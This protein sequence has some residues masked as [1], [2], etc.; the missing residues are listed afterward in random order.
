MHDIRTC[1]GQRLGRWC[2]LRV[3]RE[4][5]S[6]SKSKKCDFTCENS[7]CIWYPICIKIYQRFFWMLF[8]AIT[9][10][11]SG[12]THV[13]RISR[14]TRWSSD[15]PHDVRSRVCQA[16]I[17]WTAAAKMF[18]T[19]IQCSSFSFPH[20]LSNLETNHI[21]S[22]TSL[23]IWFSF[24]NNRQSKLC[25]WVLWVHHGPGSLSAALGFGQQ[26]LEVHFQTNI[27]QT[28]YIWQP[29]PSQLQP[30]NVPPR[31]AAGGVDYALASDTR[32]SHF[33]KSSTTSTTEDLAHAFLGTVGP[34]TENPCKSM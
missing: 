1:Q 11:L 23:C 29:K 6:L 21:E 34:V 25:Q 9:F 13:L 12:T 3:T 33:G 22:L 28:I 20:A 14:P 26:L 30:C 24:E 4:Q 32:N 2:W 27:K 31:Q 15:A 8:P 18:R 16:K 5:R 19:S 7:C 17:L 10:K